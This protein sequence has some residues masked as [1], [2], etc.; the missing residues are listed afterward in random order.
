MRKF[1]QLWFELT[2][3]LWFIP[4][5]MVVAGIAL[6]VGLVEISNNF[7]REALL[8]YPRIFGAGAQGSRGML[9][10]IAT[11]MITTAGL[12]FSLTIAALTTVSTLYTSR[13][14][15]NFM[16]ERGNQLVLGSFV[17]IFVYCLVVL[18]TI[19]GDDEIHFIPAVAIFGALVLAVISI[20]VLILYFHHLADSLQASTIISSVAHDTIQVATQLFPDELPAGEEENDGQDARE[21][22]D[23]WTDVPAEHVGYI[24]SLDPAEIE[25]FACRYDFRL[26]MECSVGDFVTR[27]TPLVSVQ[28]T[29]GK[30]DP[31][32]PAEIRRLFVFNP[33]RTIDQDVDYGLRQLVDIALRALS[34]GVNDMSTAVICV[35][36]I[37]SILEEL[38]PRRIQFRGKQAE[39]GQVVFRGPTFPGLLAT[40][41]DQI[42]ANAAGNAAIMQ[43]MLRALATIGTHT[44]SPSRRAA[45]LQHVQ[46]IWELAED[47]LDTL[48]EQDKVREDLLIALQRLGIADE[49]F[50]QRLRESRTPRAE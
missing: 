10:A 48:Y 46:R 45:L 28:T 3:S 22:S 30:L 2:S 14:L 27:R 5:L 19:R 44:E 7:D 1:K 25:A 20:G 8:Q 29:D 42:R 15:R 41:F 40:G 11:S 18:R 13:V 16:G 31:K 24:Q 49:E 33:S 34:P 6:A 21:S 35:D 32:L 23:D 43:R 38:A 47:S 12:T 9:T 17:S 39:Q 4:T 26:R 37:G 36:Y 50:S